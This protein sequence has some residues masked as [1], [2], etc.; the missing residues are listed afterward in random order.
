MEI[1]VERPKRCF[2]VNLIAKSS[3]LWVENKITLKTKMRGDDGENTII[4]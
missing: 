1:G 3:K 4:Q 2:R